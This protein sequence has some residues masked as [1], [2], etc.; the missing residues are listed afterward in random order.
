MDGSARARGLGAELR[1]LRTRTDLTQQEVGLRLGWSKAT[2]S[3]VESGA[4]ELRE[5][6]VAAILAVLG[7]SG[8][9]RERL[10]K[11]AREQ[12]QP[13][14][15]ETG[16]PGL[17]KQLTGLLK[18]ERDAT[19]IS[20]FAAILIPGLLQTASY[21]REVMRGSGVDQ[22]EIETRVTI[23]RGR[24]S[25]L[26]E[27]A[28]ELLALIDEAV[29]H[30]VVGGPTV[31][32]EQ[33]R[34]VVEMSRRRNITVRVVPLDHA[35]HPGLEGP[36]VLLE[37]PKAKPVVH[38]EQRRLGAFL[39]D[40]SDV[41]DYATVTTTLERVAMSPTDSVKLIADRAEALEDRES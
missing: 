38:L 32:A 18:F 21:A 35:V 11:L 9:E 3:R 7:V 12:D 28:V 5:A 17:P 1:Q 37:F 8:E 26:D 39:D 36:F 23:R 25:I 33:L 16:V 29:L 22:S 34:H 10:L 20:V 6:D 15:W 41:D 31:M 19:K 14:W 2:M 27:E 4:K 24:Q 40:P 30:R 13:G